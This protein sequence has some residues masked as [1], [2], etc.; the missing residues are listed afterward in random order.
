MGV[1][2]NFSR[3]GHFF[4]LKTNFFRSLHKKRENSHMYKTVFNT[5]HS[6][7]LFKILELC[8]IVVNILDV[9]FSVLCYAIDKTYRGVLSW[10]TSAWLKVRLAFQNF[11]CPFT[12]CR[13]ADYQSETSFGHFCNLIT[14]INIGSWNIVR[15]QSLLLSNFIY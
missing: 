7:T 10:P 8:I 3:E 9:G 2:R 6:F 15:F 4:Q 12:A 1:T 11:V 13:R 14:F 5:G